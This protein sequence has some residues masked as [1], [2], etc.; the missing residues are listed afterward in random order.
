MLPLI[1]GTELLAG[2]LLLSGR[3]VPLALGLL[4]PVI[5]NIVLFHLFLAPGGVALVAFVV[6]A[7]LALAWWYRAA[8]RPMLQPRTA[9]EV[10]AMEKPGNVRAAVTEA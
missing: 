4:A 2:L 7:E 9:P 10:G 6:A 3:W 5:V 1:K 8:F